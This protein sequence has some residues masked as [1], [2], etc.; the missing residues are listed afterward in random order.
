MNKD[1]YIENVGI[2]PIYIPN[3][4]NDDFKI[5]QRNESLKDYYIFGAGR[6]I[7]T[8]GCEIMLKSL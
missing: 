4:I 8:K 7:K 5:I 6:I 3:G 1:F 2:E